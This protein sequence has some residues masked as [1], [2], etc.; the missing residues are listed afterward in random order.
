MLSDGHETDRA[1]DRVDATL[2]PL[3]AIRGWSTEIDPGY[4]VFIEAM[5]SS[6]CNV[7]DVFVAHD[8]FATFGEWA[9]AAMTAALAHHDVGEPLHLLGYCAGGSLLS[10]GL[11]TL[12]QSGVRAA[13]LGFVDVR[14]AHPKVRLQRG[15]Y[16]L[17]DVPWALR[18]R[19]QLVR[20]TPPDR[21]SLISV[22]DSVL[23]RV[24]RST[25]ELPR[26][27][28]RSRNLRS[29]LTHRQAQLAACWESGTIVSP[30]HLYI[31]R[32]TMQRNWP[33]DPSLGRAGLLRGG[34]SVCI[35]EGDH[36]S[37]LQPPNSAGL[38]AQIN[39][40]RQKVHSAK[41]TLNPKV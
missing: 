22:A 38:I 37:C 35:I 20:L 15:T 5:R 40:D 9:D 2:P 1:T 25:I 13:Y 36:H 14:A 12:E 41:S 10:E 27:G 7:V 33:G 18:I 24:I 39:I 8:E 23:R 17:Y 6:G 21:E 28:W 31:C 30:A 26:R 19:N 29:P 4:Q 3:I 34:F 11:R 32:D 16:S